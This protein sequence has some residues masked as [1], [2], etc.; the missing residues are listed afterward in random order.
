MRPGRVLFAGHVG[1]IYQG[2]GYRVAGRSARRTQWQLPDGVYLNGVTMQKIRGQ[3][4]G[5]EAAERRLV[6]RYGARPI[7]AGEQPAAWLRDAVRDDPSVGLRLVQHRGCHRYLRV[8]GTARQAAQVK[9]NRRLRADWASLDDREALPVGPYPK[10]PDR[11]N[12]GVPAARSAAAGRT[13][14]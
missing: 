4:P 2:G 8:L 12:R 14:G 9:I 13:V 3:K 7:R 10:H 6:Q 1:Y 11:P 5:H